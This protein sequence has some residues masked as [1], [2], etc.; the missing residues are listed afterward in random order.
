MTNLTPRFIIAGIV[1][2]VAGIAIAVTQEGVGPDASWVGGVVAAIG[3]GLIVS[4][5]R[6]YW[7]QHDER[8][9]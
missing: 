1:L 3:G 9:D 8:Q 4:G 2:V 6:R 5:V 7:Q